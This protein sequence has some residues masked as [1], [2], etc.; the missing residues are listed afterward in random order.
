M[1]MG[2]VLTVTDRDVRSLYLDLIRRNLTRYGMH[3]RMPARWSLRRRLLFKSANAVLPMLNGASPFGQSKRDLG[4]DW[5]A[6][7][8]TMIGM[9]R[10]T[11]LQHCVETVLAED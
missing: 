10:L 2:A 9:Q 7:A 8:E 11:S 4:I 6:E 5:P 3:E 1:G